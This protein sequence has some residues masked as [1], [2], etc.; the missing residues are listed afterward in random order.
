MKEVPDKRQE[1]NST[2]SHKAEKEDDYKGVLVVHEM[3]CQPGAAVCNTAIGELDIESAEGG[4]KVLDKQTVEEANRRVSTL[5]QH[6]VIA[7]DRLG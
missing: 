1:H 2:S 5:F 4:G 3:V 6:N 7:L